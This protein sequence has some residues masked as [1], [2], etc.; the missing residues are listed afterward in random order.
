MIFF[1]VLIL[2]LENLLSSLISSRHLRDFVLF[3][4]DSLLLLLLLIFWL[5]GCFIAV[6]WLSLVAAHRLACCDMQD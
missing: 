1:L 5:H 4:I 2:N 3:L 6:N